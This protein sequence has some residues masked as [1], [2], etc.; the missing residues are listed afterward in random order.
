MPVISWP[1]VTEL[2]F[3]V[4]NQEI[5]LQQGCDL[6][7]VCRLSAGGGIRLPSSSINC[8]IVFKLFCHTSL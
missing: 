4:N 1:Q 8:G 2:A 5:Q 7:N 6:S 3:Y